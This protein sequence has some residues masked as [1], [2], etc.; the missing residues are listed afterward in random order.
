MYSE[1]STTKTRAL[2]WEVFVEAR[3]AAQGTLNLES[4]VAAKLVWARM[5][6]HECIYILDTFLSDFFHP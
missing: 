4:T 2:C 5:A 3:P 6:A 1:T